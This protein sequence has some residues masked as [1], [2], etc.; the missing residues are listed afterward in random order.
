MHM[1]TLGVATLAIATL[2][3]IWRSYREVKTHHEQ[4]R[5]ERVA[6]LLWKA[7]TSSHQPAE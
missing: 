4:K 5:R 3:Y 1:V 6:F 7:T 2:Y